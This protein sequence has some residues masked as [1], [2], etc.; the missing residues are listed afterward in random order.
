M[1]GYH[2]A[3]VE[4]RSEG[5]PAQ[6]SKSKL[7]AELHLLTHIRIDPSSQQKKIFLKKSLAAAI[8]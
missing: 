4:V 8:F 3:C 1:S 7:F 2:P 5:C 6:K